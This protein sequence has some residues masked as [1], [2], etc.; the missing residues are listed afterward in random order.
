MISIFI[1]GSTPDDQLTSYD[2][3]KS[4]SLNLN[5]H[6]EEFEI[7]SSGFPT[8]KEAMEMVEFEYEKLRK[9]CNE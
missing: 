8:L 3:R 2:Y 7:R 4:G 9:D 6:R 5:G 1:F